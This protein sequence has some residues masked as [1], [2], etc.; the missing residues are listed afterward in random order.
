MNLDLRLSLPV[1]AA[2]LV[3][4]V[5]IGVP[6]WAPA[7]A[8]ALWLATGTLIAGA[9][10]SPRRFLASIALGCALAALCSTSVAVHAE[11][12][13]PEA[14]AELA[15]KHTT[16]TAIATTT[17][18]VKDSADFF[19]ATITTL[20]ADGESIQ[21]ESPALIFA[22]RGGFAAVAA[23]PDESQEEARGGVDGR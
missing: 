13:Q 19:Q 6:A 8:I 15:A 23:E 14:L 4:V 17:S 5:V 22:E 7:V 21:I 11:T 16:V 9:L 3:A 18:A 10:L 1:A 2:W 20:E 12:R